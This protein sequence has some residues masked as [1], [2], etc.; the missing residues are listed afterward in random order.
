M[1]LPRR[2]TKAQRMALQQMGIS[3]Q[4]IY[5]WDVWKV[6]VG[7]KHAKD[8]AAVLGVPLAAVLY[9][10]RPPELGERGGGTGDHPRE[11]KAAG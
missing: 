1:A 11:Q 6:G 5:L 2:F 8:V 3:R 10:K 7:L 9:P 4:L